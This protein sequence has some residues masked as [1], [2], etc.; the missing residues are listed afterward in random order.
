MTTIE[1]MRKALEALDEPSYKTEK[2]VAAIT[3][4]RAEIARLEAAEPVAWADPKSVTRLQ[5]LPPGSVQITSISGSCEPPW[6]QPIYTTP[7]PPAAIPALT[8]EELR[9]AYRERC[10]DMEPMLTD[11]IL[12]RWAYALAAERAG[13]EIK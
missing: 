1:V 11:I 8:D 12:A 3:A 2:E 9:A 7:T 4:L 10:G 13:V 5:R 6:T